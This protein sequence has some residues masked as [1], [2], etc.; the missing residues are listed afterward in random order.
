MEYA[1]IM[2]IATQQGC[3]GIQLPHYPKI[4]AAFSPETTNS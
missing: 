1:Q 4:L 3:K 2:A